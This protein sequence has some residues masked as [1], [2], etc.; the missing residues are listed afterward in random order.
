[1]ETLIDLPYISDAN[2]RAVLDALT[3]AVPA[4]IFTDEN[5]TSLILCKMVNLSLEYGNCDASCFAYAIFAS[6]LGPYFGDTATG[7]RFG[8]LAFDMVEKPGLGRYKARV[9]TVFAIR[10]NPW[11]KHV[12]TSQAL[13]RRAFDIAQETGDLT[14][15]TYSCSCL[16]TI[17]L[18]SANP[19]D[20]V[21]D[22]AERSL[23]FA[24]KA[25]FGV[26]VDFLIAQLR[27]IRTL[28]GLTPDIRSFDDTGFDEGQFE[29]HLEA[30]PGLAMATCWY[31]VR[32]LQMRFLAG[33]HAAALSAAA[34]AA[35]LLWTSA[36]FFEI[37]EYHFFCALAHAAQDNEARADERRERMQTIAAHCKQLETWA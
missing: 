4:A 7:F 9:S 30:N 24:Q 25:K 32:K 8:K 14:F 21:Q 28:R 34:K 13:T 36:S 12:R 5:L 15:A 20:E 22:E 16:I 23:E 31:W 18:A 27:L 6:V 33:E 26:V 11:T 29:Q 2:W 17:L 10:V 3:P 1:T 37:A 19:L 35:T